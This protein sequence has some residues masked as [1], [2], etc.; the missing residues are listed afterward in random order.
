MWLLA[1]YFRKWILLEWSINNCNDTAQ[2]DTGERFEFDSRVLTLYWAATIVY[3]SF[4]SHLRNWFCVAQW[5]SHGPAWRL[6]ALVAQPVDATFLP[7]LCRPHI[8]AH[9]RS[10]GG[11][12]HLQLRTWLCVLCR[13]ETHKRQ[14]DIFN[15]PSS[16]IHAVHAM[17]FPV[18]TKMTSLLFYAT[19]TVVFPGVFLQNNENKSCAGNQQETVT[20]LYCMKCFLKR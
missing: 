7:Q 18:E 17:Y 8:S 14:K 1:V 6:A 11:H 19:G 5:G 20:G 10:A 3:I 16:L 2:S 13:S 12:P 15:F 9:H 4:S